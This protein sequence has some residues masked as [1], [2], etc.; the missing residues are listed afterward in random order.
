MDDQE[1]VQPEQGIAFE[2]VIGCASLLAKAEDGD[3]LSP[4]TQ[5][6]AKVFRQQSQQRDKN[7]CQQSEKKK[8]KAGEFQPALREKKKYCQ[9]DHESADR[10]SGAAQFLI[11]SDTVARVKAGEKIR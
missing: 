3:G 4:P 11:R 5:A 10:V 6:V 8:H 7:D 2:K 1:R 9:Q